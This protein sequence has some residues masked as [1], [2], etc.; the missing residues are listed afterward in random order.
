VNKSSALV[1]SAKVAAGFALL[2][3][4][5]AMLV[6]PGPGLPLILWSLVL[7]EEEFP[8]AARVRETLMALAR[9]GMTWLQRAV[10]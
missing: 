9:R 3:V 1:R 5:I 4:G 10:R 7:L 2:P 6:L 8:W